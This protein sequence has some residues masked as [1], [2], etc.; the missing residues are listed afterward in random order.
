LGILYVSPDT[1][2]GVPDDGLIGNLEALEEEEAGEC[3]GSRRPRC[4]PVGLP[5]GACLYM[6]VRH[7]HTRV[8]GSSQ[9]TNDQRRNT[10][11][12]NPS[13]DI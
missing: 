13:L 9:S 10:T 7:I 2:I 5:S 12:K 4:V 11:L 8:R 1:L 3:A 6:H